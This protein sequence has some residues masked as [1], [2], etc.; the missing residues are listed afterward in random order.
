MGA[1]NRTTAQGE[2]EVQLRVRVRGSKPWLFPLSL[3]LGLVVLGLV[4]RG[5]VR[6]LRLD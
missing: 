2:G 5:W 3:A 6:K 4:A 1:S